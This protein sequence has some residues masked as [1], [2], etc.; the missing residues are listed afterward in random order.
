ML[1]ICRAAA[2]GL[3]VVLAL[4]LGALAQGTVPSQDWERLASRAEVMLSDGEATD[5]ALEQ[6]RS[7]I[8]GYRE[9]FLGAQNTGQA[10]VDTIQAQIDA[11]GPAPAEGETEPEEIA[12]RRSELT[13]QLQ[14]ILAPRRSAEEAFNR[15]NG[16]ISEIDT[17][18]R[19]RQTQEFLKLGPT[20]LNPALWPKA[21]TSLAE[22]LVRAG[23][24]VRD[25]LGRPGERAHLREN[26]PATLLY[27]S[28]ALALLVRG[29]SWMEWLTLRI[30]TGSAGQ[31]NPVVAFI[32]SIGQVVVPVLGLF[33]LREALYSS[34][35]LGLRGQ[36]FAET[37]PRMGFIVFASLWLGSR[38]FPWRDHIVGPFQIAAEKRREGRYYFG[39][40]GLL[41][42]AHGLLTRVAA[43]D[44]Y[45]EA[46]V[47]VLFFPLTLVGG[48]V[49]WRLGRMM[50]RLRLYDAQ[51]EEQTDASEGSYGNNLLRLV[52]QLYIL[53]GMIAPLVA[54]IGYGNAGQQLIFP[55]AATL[56][57]LALLAVLRIVVR[58]IYGLITRK[59]DQEVGEALTPVL[60]LF[61]LYVASIP[62]FALIWGMRVTDLVEIWARFQEGIPIGDS[63]ISPT[64]F[65]TFALVFALLFGLTRLLQGTLRSSVLPRTKIDVGGR[66]AITSG[67]G[68]IG[69]FLAGVVAI[70]SA[71]IDLSS[72]AL[73]AG[74]LS[75]GIG[76]GLQNIVSNFVAGIILLIERPISEG[77]W[78][79]VGGQMG[80]V[81]DISVRS[82]RIETFDRTD[83]IVPNADFVS[84][85]VTNWTRGNLVGRVIVPVSVA[86]GTD[87][88]LVEKVLMRI[89]EDHP[90]VVLNPEPGIIFMGFDHD[91]MNFEIR[92]ILRDVNFV[93]SVKSDMN[94]AITAAFAQEGI[95]MPFPQRDLWLRNPEMLRPD[96]PVAEGPGPAPETPE[97][98]RHREIG[99][100]EGDGDGDA[101]G[102]GR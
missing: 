97:P 92:A 60:I 82:T 76:F 55:S 21:V 31:G 44:R 47:A 26:L 74:A 46:T 102:A 27:L 86:F 51:A 68:Y 4:A 48:L 22:S 40:M 25:G 17:T 2:L 28:L 20:P 8:A 52:G 89:A 24:E 61:V 80:Y 10:R 98:N 45:D 84:G 56:G 101:D 43:F 69:I 81:R 3:V 34:G 16:L 90:M 93:L 79:E 73:V 67:V 50:H 9:K 57:L 75:V 64:D 87:T 54:A 71:G 91:R 99:D 36:I 5:L 19:E 66:T 94:H 83:V 12:A 63:R 53:I 7:E 62:L 23:E 11:L 30:Y 95:A 49:L 78:I 14:T 77:D 65:L 37:L 70:S 88:R 32:V 41:I 18:L 38:V 29:R 72:V 33:A 85:V 58:D 42:A 1:R 15:A 6:L 100:A 39:L 59:S 13:T 96:A 35:I